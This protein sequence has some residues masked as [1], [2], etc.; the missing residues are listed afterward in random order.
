M[1]SIAIRRGI[2]SDCDALSHMYAALWPGAAA[3][4]YAKEIAPVLAGTSSGTMP[5]VVFVAEDAGV[6]AGFIEVGLRS[7]ADGCDSRQPVGFLEGWFV[8]ESY[9]RL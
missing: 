7:H 8:L 9:R 4:E 5:L 3:A 2:S 6:L 1:K